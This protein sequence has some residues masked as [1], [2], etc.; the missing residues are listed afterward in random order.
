MD[1]F[2]ALQ[3]Q[4]LERI[5]LDPRFHDP[6]VLLKAVRNGLVYGTKVRFPHAFVMVLLF[7]SGTLREKLWLIFKATRQHATN[8]AKFALLYKSSMLALKNVNGGKEESVHTFLAGLFG[9][10]WVFG[11]GR[12]A[13]S[14]VNQQIVIYV[15]AR[16]VLAT[17]K[18]AVQPPGDNSLVAGS[19]GGR[20]GKGLL[21]LS[22]QQLEAVRR[23]SWPV[24]A[25]LSWAS[26]MWLFRYYPETLQ[27]SLRSSMTYI[28][29]NAEK[30]DGT[31]NLL[32][33]NK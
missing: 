29:S 28:Y 15:F 3:Q 27:P 31:R 22:G 21:G 33:H 1:N 17:A 7:R 6:L 13:N 32:W 11:H 23:N 2:K 25:S 18:L 26:V 30:W 19:Y 10:Y 20:G 9:G 24:F 4:Q 16:V 5:I 14:S 12:S 8:L